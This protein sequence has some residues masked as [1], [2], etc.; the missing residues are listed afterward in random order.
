[1]RIASVEGFL[2]Y[3]GST[4]NLLFCRIE[5][6]CGLHGWGEAYVTAEKEKS[7]FEYMQAMAAHLVGRSAYNIR[8]AGQVLFD[9]FAIR[10][11]SLTFLSSWSA[12]EMALWDLVGKKAGMPVY[13]LLGG[14]MRGK[15]RVYANGWADEP[16]TRDQNIERAVRVVA[17]GYS[18]LKFDPLPGPWRTF[19]DRKDE[20]FAVDY[21]RAMREALGPDVELLIE[22]HRRLAPMH[23][24]RLARRLEEFNVGWYEEPCLSD[25]IDLLSEVRSAIQI[26]IVTGETL[27]TKEDYARVFEKRAADILNPDICAI[28][29]ISAMM[30]IAAMAQP[31]A[32]AI[33]PHNNNST[34]SGLAATVHACAAMPNFLIAECFVNRLDACAEIA[35]QGIEVKEGWVDLP[36]TPG[37]G[38]DIDVEALRRNPFN[39][40]PPKGL[41]HY[42]EEFPRQNYAV[43]ETLQGATGV[44]R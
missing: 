44:A 42:W 11:S 8:H 20:D 29:G 36:D 18:A 23:A 21:V 10:R 32:V 14:A 4:R 25:N 7:V 1:M 3:P 13:N 22:I 19:I 6:E 35:L 33:A 12:I 39:D 34:L 30:D 17:S 9:D 24:I 2:F 43:G 15:I 27:Y 41:R 16:G 40:S 38:I 31:H 28:G 5:T 37:L 26:P